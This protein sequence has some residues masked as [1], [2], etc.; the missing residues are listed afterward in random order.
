MDK[1]Q[2][3]APRSRPKFGIQDRFYLAVAVWIES[4]GQNA[5][6]LLSSRVNLNQFR[7]FGDQ[8]DSANY[9]QRGMICVQFLNVGD[10]KCKID[11]IEVIN[12][13]S[14][15]IRAILPI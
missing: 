6:E 11:P 1:C 5:D 14:I 10:T 3:F 15:D 8:V 12:E 4:S 9:L 7:I 2:R 13:A